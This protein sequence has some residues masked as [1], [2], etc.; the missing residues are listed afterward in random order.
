MKFNKIVLSLVLVCSMNLQAAFLPTIAQPLVILKCVL[1][2]NKLKKDCKDFYKNHV[3]SKKAAE[4]TEID[5][6]AESVFT[7][8]ATANACDI[9]LDLQER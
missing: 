6:S 9:L 5:Q 1:D 3:N 2:L 8:E 7:I 4:D